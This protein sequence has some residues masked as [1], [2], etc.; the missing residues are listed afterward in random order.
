MKTNEVQIEHFGIDFGTTNIAVS[1]LIVDK[2][3]A[4]A[5]RVPY[6]ENGMP[7][8]SM[9]AVKYDYDNGKPSGR[10]GRNVKNQ[11]SSMQEEGYKIIKSIKTSLGNDTAFYEIGPLKMSAKEI[12]TVLVKGIKQYLATQ[13]ERKVTVKSA[14][15]AVPVDFSNKQR[16]ELCKAF[17]DAGIQVNKIVSESMAAFIRNRETVQA[18]SKVM[19]FDWGGGTLDI[20]LLSVEKGKAYEESTFGWKVAGDK[21]DEAIAVFI[22]NQLVKKY[23]LTTSFSSL[24]LRDKIKILSA[25]EKAKI[26]FSEKD[27]DELDESERIIMFDYCGQKKVIYELEYG[28]FKEVISQIVNQAVSCIHYALEKADVDLINLDAIIM[29]GGSSN[30]LPL[31]EKIRKEFEEKYKKTI[32]YPANPDW[33]VAEGAAIIDSIDCQYALNQDI[34]VVMSDNSYYPVIPK[35]SKIPF[36][37]DPVTFGI[38]DDATSA[39]FILV[40]DKKNILD[41]ITMPAKGFMGEYFEVSGKIGNNLVAMVSVVGN[42]KMQKIGEKHTEINQLSYYCNISEVEDLK[43]EIIG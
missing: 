29:V 2:E 24:S 14:T 27:D 11:T 19:V 21:M 1:G 25:S 8:P 7:F 4:R 38:V 20:S 34:S 22:H 3:S 17:N 42:S 40:D 39:H 10:F 9:V 5:F 35:G 41:R 28:D 31:K 6:G 13:L 26:N 12:A 32:I 37:G 15:I 33:S 36:D 30:L 16:E 43:F 23:N 18:F